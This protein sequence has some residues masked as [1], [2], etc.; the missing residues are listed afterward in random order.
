MFFNIDTSYKNIICDNISLLHTVSLIAGRNCSRLE[1]SS[2]LNC[3]LSSRFLTFFALSCFI[4]MWFLRSS[5]VSDVMGANG[6]FDCAIEWNV[7]RP[8]ALLSIPF[9]CN[10]MLRTCSPWSWNVSEGKS[11]TPPKSK[12]FRCF[13]LLRR[14]RLTSSTI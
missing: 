14:L 1:E 9:D 6:S 2:C 4:R 10:E 13:R 3:S 11:S 5:R 7:E 12:E 8:D